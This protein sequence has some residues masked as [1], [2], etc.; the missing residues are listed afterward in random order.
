MSNVTWVEAQE[1]P[2]APTPAVSITYSCNTPTS[3]ASCSHS[4]LSI[5]TGGCVS[6]PAFHGVW[7]PRLATELAGALI[8]MET[9]ICDLCIPPS[10]CWGCGVQVEMLVTVERSYTSRSRHKAPAHTQV[11]PGSLWQG[12]L[13]LEFTTPIASSHLS[14]CWPP[15]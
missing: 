15:S 9:C 2:S 5:T 4:P 11:T 12:V 13:A 8:L 10:V 3:Q 6:L 1:T 7:L 14:D